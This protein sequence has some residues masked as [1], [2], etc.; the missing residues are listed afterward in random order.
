MTDLSKHQ[1]RSGRRRRRFLSPVQKYEAFVQ[2]LTGEMTVAECAD[3]WGVDRSTIMRARE[4]AKRGALDA[5][6]SSRPGVRAEGP[7]PE[8][9]MARD[10]AA[11][12]ARRSRRW[13]SRSPCWREK[14]VGGD[15]RRGP[16]CRGRHQSGSVGPR[17]RRRRGGLDHSPACAVLELDGRRCRRWQHRREAGRLDDHTAGGTALHAITP[18]ERRA[19]VELFERWGD[20]G[21]GYRK[22]AHRGSYVN[23]VWVS[24]STLYRVLAGEGLV[25]PARSAHPFRRVPWGTG[26]SGGATSSGSTT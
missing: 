12:W 1:E 21:G 2:V 16:A 24:P 5:L 19:I 15:R 7:D 14:S 25:M 11:A 18:A 22:L 13:P 9:V 23:L 17:R 8:L 10:E 20:I 4:V 26:S 6:A 3:H